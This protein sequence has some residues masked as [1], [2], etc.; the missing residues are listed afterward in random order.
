METVRTVADLREIL[1]PA[2]QRGMTIGFVPTMGYLHAGHEALMRRARAECD[3]VVASIFVNPLQFGPREDFASYPRDWERDT[4]LASGAGVDVL[5]APE[6]GE[7]YPQGFSTYVTV[8]GLSDVLCGAYRP[9]HFRGVAT[10]VVKLLNIVRPDRAY[11]GQKDAQQLLI[12][13]RL[14]RDLNLDTAVVAVPTVREPDGLAMSSRNVYLNPEERRAATALYRALVAAE[15]AV[16]AGERAGERLCAVMTQVLEA[17]PLV[18]V[19]Y[20]AAVDPDTLRP[21]AVLAD[22][23]LLAVAAHVGKA[24]LIDNLALSLGPGGPTRITL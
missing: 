6:A 4:R 1:L 20:A 17:E 15:A 3:L 8:E 14:V 11:F 5:F 10:V 2:R 23:V 13:R 9:G 12:I 21:L 7:M 24:R 19:Q 18:R 16:A 22:R